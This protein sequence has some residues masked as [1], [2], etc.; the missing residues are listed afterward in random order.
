VSMADER[1][2]IEKAERN[3]RRELAMS[4]ACA[5]CQAGPGACCV[6]VRGTNVGRDLRW[7]YGSVKQDWHTSRFTVAMESQLANL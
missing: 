7:P 5:Y 3:A 2:E 4:V 6:R 1:I